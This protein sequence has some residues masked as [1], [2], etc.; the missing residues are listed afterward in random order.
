M[1]FFRTRFQNIGQVKLLFGSDVKPAH[2]GPNSHRVSAESSRVA[3]GERKK[4]SQESVT[5]KVV[6]SSG[7]LTFLSH[8]TKGFRLGVNCDC[9]IYILRTVFW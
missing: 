2:L 7:F 4:C 6:T 3:G 9:D 1:G 8:W 5:V